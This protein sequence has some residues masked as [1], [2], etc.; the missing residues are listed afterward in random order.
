M[1]KIDRCRAETGAPAGS[2]A[3]RRCLRTVGRPAQLSRFLSV[4]I[5]VLGMVG[6]MPAAAGCQAAR[7]GCVPI[8]DPCCGSMAC[9]L[10]AWPPECR[11]SPPREGEV[12][13]ILS[14]CAGEDL[15]C[16]GFQDGLAGR[17]TRYSRLGEECDGIVTLC[18][19]RLKCWPDPRYPILAALRGQGR[20]FPAVETVSPWLPTDTGTCLDSY[21]RALHRSLPWGTGDYGDV[22]SVR[23]PRAIA[24]GRGYAGT[25]VAGGSVE[26]GGVYGSD[27][28]YGCYHSECFVDE[29]GAGVS[30][31]VAVGQYREY[32]N[33][34]GLGYTAYLGVAAFVGA[35]RGLAWGIDPRTIDPSD[36]LYQPQGDLFSLSV[37]LDVQAV[38]GVSVCTTSVNT[39]VRNWQE[40]TGPEAKCADRNVC[41]AAPAACTA[42]VS[43][44]DGSTVPAGGAPV[45]EQIPP[46]PYAIGETEVTLRVT[47]GSGASDECSALVD[48]RDCTPPVLACR[49]TVAEC[50]HDRRAF[51][52]PLPPTVEE[53]S[54]YSVNGPVAG[55]Y[56]LGETPVQ[57]VVTDV[58][59]NES[60]CDTRI[61]VVDTQ[62]PRIL[63]ATANPAVLW[64]PNHKVQRV[65]ISIDAR[66]A[67]DPDAACVLTG[68]ESN[69]SDRSWWNWNDRPGDARIVGPR[70]VEL[71]AERSG[72][73]GGR[74]Y[75]VRFECA[76]T[77]AGNVSHGSVQVE[78]P[79]DMRK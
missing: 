63:S 58:Y 42:A 75:T 57:F 6:S 70:T 50:Q 30:G 78:V 1:L 51:V 19:D 17:C 38:A 76:D 4:L 21:S 7:E 54:A 48:V 43:I 44:D 16:K 3:Y 36:P 46:G 55:E 52:A 74:V 31:F 14:G 28:S 60:S 64:P 56:P 24:F 79:H 45:L 69:E 2:L 5:F 34:G 37:G 22:A 47:D 66:D 11:H 41:A 25:A 49:E 67:C 18:G 12:C 68:I 62:P 59:F 15:Y 8:F 27:G 53:C 32:E 29:I 26:V 61:R 71:R 73:G 72:F 35:N 40:I 20:C 39:V 13:T 33:A 10:T 23:E 65:Q 77:T 9:E